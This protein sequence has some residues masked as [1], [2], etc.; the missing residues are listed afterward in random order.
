[1]VAT[2]RVRHPNGMKP[3]CRVRVRHPNR[4]MSTEPGS[5]TLADSCSS[6]GRSAMTVHQHTE[7]PPRET[8][9]AEAAALRDAEARY[10]N[11]F[12][13]SDAPDHRLPTVG[14]SAPDAMRLL[15]EE[16]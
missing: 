11:A 12:L 13:L 10:G 9:G 16:L 14:M 3:R 2:R 4:M 6:Q 1:M 5:T 7:N 15:G 8:N